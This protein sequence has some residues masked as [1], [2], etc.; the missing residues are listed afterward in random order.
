MKHSILLKEKAI[1]LYLSGK[2]MKE[3]AAELEIHEATVQRWMSKEKVS[4]HRGPLSL[5]GKEDFFDVIDTEEKAYWLGFIMADGCVNIYNGQYC[6]K[7]HIAAKDS[8]IIDNFL[9]AIESKNKPYYRTDINGN[10][11]YAISLSSKHM[12]ESL[13]SLG[14]VP[15]KTGKECLPNLSGELTR[16]FVRGFFDGDGITDI[17]QRRSG[18]VSSRLMLEQLQTEL[19][20]NQTI[21]E[22]NGAHYYLG[23]LAFSRWLYHYIYSDCTIY[24]KRKRD[25]MWNIL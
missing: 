21:F 14:V 4:R 22:N 16:H 5:I 24:L 8:E 12:V 10:Q 17:S 20:T 13:I 6:L 9:L 23:G 25:R 19:G 11:T 1:E 7:I 2:K 18:F 3:V 15:N